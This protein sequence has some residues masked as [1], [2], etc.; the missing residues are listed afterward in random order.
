M[1]EQGNYGGLERVKMWVLRQERNSLRERESA[2]QGQEGVELMT[3]VEWYVSG[4]NDL[5]FIGR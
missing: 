1:G 4:T 2:L 3:V 5:R